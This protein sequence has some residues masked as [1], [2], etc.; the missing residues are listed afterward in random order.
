M[1]PGHYLISVYLFQ[2]NDLFNCQSFSC[3]G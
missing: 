3:R 1:F 2:R